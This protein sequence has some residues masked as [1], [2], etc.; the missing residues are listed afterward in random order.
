MFIV[1][2]FPFFLGP[3]FD[4]AF[5]A[6][7]YPLGGPLGAPHYDNHR[8]LVHWNQPPPVHQ[9]PSPPTVGAKSDGDDDDDDDGKS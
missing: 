1:Y 8:V 9:G 7:Q 4:A 2:I 5:T 3:G 6:S